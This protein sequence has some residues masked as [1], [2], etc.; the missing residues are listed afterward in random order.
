M[1]FQRPW[2]AGAPQ[3]EFFIRLTQLIETFRYHF[4]F[5]ENMMRSCRFKGL[6]RHAEEHLTIIEQMRWLQ[7]EMGA[8][9]VDQ[10]GSVVRCM[11]DWTERHITGADKNFACYLHEGAVASRVFSDAE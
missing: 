11:R 2:G 7:D 1:G 6:K 3:A 9:Y 5:E 8:G 10:C 4:D